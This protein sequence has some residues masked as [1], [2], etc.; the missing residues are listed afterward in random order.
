MS[1]VELYSS[2]YVGTVGRVKHVRVKH[3][4]EAIKRKGDGDRETTAFVLQNVFERRKRIS[5][6]LSS[7]NHSSFFPVNDQ[8]GSVRGSR[9][10]SG[11]PPFVQG[12][13]SSRLMKLDVTTAVGRS[14][15]PQAAS[16]HDLCTYRTKTSFEGCMFNP[17]APRELSPELC[18]TITEAN[19]S[20]PKST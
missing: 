6:L 10:P 20:I 9:C 19:I 4:Q 13:F 2:S 7:E 8:W 5:F 17:N 16:R 1:T 15:S 14:E 18:A 3:A 12:L 11:L